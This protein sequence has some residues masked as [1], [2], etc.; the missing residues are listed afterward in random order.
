MNDKDKIITTDA[1]LAVADEL[2]SRIPLLG[3]AWDLSKALYG[4]GMKLR[5]DRALEWVEMVVDNPSYF[6]KEI[7]SDPIFQDGFALALE[8]Y[9]TER[10]EENR[11]YFR[12]VFLGYTKASD[13]ELFPMEKYLH[14]LSQ[15][16][17]EDIAVLR[18]VD[19]GRGDK[20]YQIYGDSEKNLSNIYN[21]I[22]AG[23]IHN[24]AS[25]R[26][27]PQTAPF[28]WISRFGDSF[29]EYIKD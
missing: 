12:N 11:K 20:N 2:V 16:S 5:Q 13:K 23:I 25:S 3:L 29:A 28:V 24:D 26:M 7:L 1:A 6:T 21:L 9:L 15:L 19:L 18:D 17:A 4:A 22:N 8:K 27:G 14:T 10:S